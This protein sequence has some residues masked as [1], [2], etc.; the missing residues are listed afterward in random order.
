MSDYLVTEIEKS[1]KLQVRCRTEVVDG[2]G[3]GYLETLT[4]HDLSSDATELVPASPA[5]P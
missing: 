5:R 3:R 4:L 1:P 2:G